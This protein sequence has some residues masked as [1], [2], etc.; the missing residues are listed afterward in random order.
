MSCHRHKEDPAAGRILQLSAA[1]RW[2]SHRAC[3]AVSKWRQQSVAQ[4]TAP[5]CPRMIDYSPH[6]FLPVNQLPF[7]LGCSRGEFLVTAVRACGLQRAIDGWRMQCTG[8]KNRRECTRKG[9]QLEC[10]PPL[11]PLDIYV[12]ACSTGISVP[13]FSLTAWSVL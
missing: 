9:C 1:P 4:A 11:R 13:V 12:C 2:V 10:F 7:N 8:D 5:S 3:G 6:I